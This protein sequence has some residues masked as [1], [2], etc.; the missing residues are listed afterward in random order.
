MR[1][2]AAEDLFRREIEAAIE[3][4]AD[5]PETWPRF[6]HGTRRFVLRVC[7]FT[8]VYTTGD[9]H[10]LIVAI[11]HGKR[12]PGYWASRVPSKPARSESTP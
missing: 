1:S 6:V 8:I 11:A 9:D 12:K 5:S 4:I 10:V 7:P 3:H 2:A